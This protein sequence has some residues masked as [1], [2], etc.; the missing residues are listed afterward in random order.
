MASQ[1]PRSATNKTQNTPPCG[2]QSIKSIAVRLSNNEN[3]KI[4]KQSQK[5]EN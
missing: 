5:W 1:N 2:S 4:E 3:L